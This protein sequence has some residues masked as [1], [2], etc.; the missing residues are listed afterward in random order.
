MLFPNIA[1]LALPSPQERILTCF[2]GRPHKI[3]LLQRRCRQVI[4]V[5]LVSLLRL[6]LVKAGQLLLLR[7]DLFI[8]RCLRSSDLGLLKIIRNYDEVFEEPLVFNLMHGA[9]IQRNFL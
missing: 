6:H 3:T 5:Q 1:S 2:I 9:V 8:H 4:Y 7:L